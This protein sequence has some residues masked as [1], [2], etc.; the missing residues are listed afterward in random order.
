VASGKAAQRQQ[1]IA[2]FIEAVNRFIAAERARDYPN[3]I[4]IASR[5]QEVRRG[6]FGRTHTEW[7]GEDK[8]G[9]QLYMRRSYDSYDDRWVTYEDFKLTL[10]GQILSSGEVV[11]FDAFV[12]GHDGTGSY[13]YEEALRYLRKNS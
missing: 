11:S 1:R 8:Y 9:W 10:D 7:V 12:N 13:G 6:S 4:Q 2:E 3:I 5:R